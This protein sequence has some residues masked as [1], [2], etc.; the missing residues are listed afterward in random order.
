MLLNKGA[1]V[2]TFLYEGQDEHLSP[3]V[4]SL[5][6]SDA[7]DHGPSFLSYIPFLFVVGVA[8]EGIRNSRPTGSYQWRENSCSDD[9]R[10]RI[11]NIGR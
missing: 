10:E 11:L 9:G 1:N 3:R 4:N 8:R 6:A 7:A 2:P 5:L